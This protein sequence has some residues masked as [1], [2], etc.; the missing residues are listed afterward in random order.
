MWNDQTAANLTSIMENQVFCINIIYKKTIVYFLEVQILC[1]SVD[2]LWWLVLSAIQNGAHGINVRMWWDEWGKLGNLCWIH[3]QLLWAVTH[4]KSDT[5][6]KHLLFF[7]LISLS[8][9]LAGS[10][11]Y[12][13]IYLPLLIIVVKYAVSIVP[14]PLIWVCL[15]M[16]QNLT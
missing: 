7:L 2:C 4:S 6:Q 13:N 12:L 10:Q 9:F 8:L 16:P 11:F 5:R 1:W 15:C 14:P 3:F